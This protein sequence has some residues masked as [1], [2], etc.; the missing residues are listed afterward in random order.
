MTRSL[1]VYILRS[2][3]YDVH[4][5]QRSTRADQLRDVGELFDEETRNGGDARD[6]DVERS[7]SPKRRIRR[8]GV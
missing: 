8:F 7:E 2:D 3:L 6:V 1:V 4:S 5:R